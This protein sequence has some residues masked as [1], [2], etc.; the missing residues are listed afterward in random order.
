MRIPLAKEVTEKIE[1]GY[2]L[3]GLTWFKWTLWGLKFTY[4]T[5][6]DKKWNCS[7][8]VNIERTD[9]T[10]E[11]YN[12][13]F[14]IDEKFLHLSPFRS[15]GIPLK[16]QG[17]VI[18]LNFR[19]DGLYYDFIYETEY[20]AHVRVKMSSTGEFEG[21]IIVPPTWDLAKREKILLASAKNVNVDCLDILEHV[22]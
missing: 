7:N 18:G 4:F 6:P 10:E 21:K 16:G 9:F 12:N 5:A 15:F 14:E 20:L 2:V 3:T 8:I 17:Y 22:A 1:K 19:Q 11:E 13:G